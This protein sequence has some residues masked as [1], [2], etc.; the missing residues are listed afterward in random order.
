MD[1]K[2]NDYNQRVQ[3][4]NNLMLNAMG[5]YKTA[6]QNEDGSITHYT[7]DKPTLEESSYISCETSNGFAYTNDGW[8]NGAPH[9]K[10][11][12]TKDG[13]MICNVLSAV[14][15][16]ADWIKTGRI[17]SNDGSCYF[18]LDN[19]KLVANVLST[20]GIVSEWIQSGRV[21]SSSGTYGFDLDNGQLTVQN[22]AANL[23][24]TKRIQAADASCYCDLAN[25]QISMSNVSSA[26]GGNLFIFYDD[27]QEIRFACVPQNTFLAEGGV[28]YGD[29]DSKWTV[30]SSGGGSGY[31]II[32]SDNGITFSGPNNTILQKWS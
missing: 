3:A 23:L 31:R 12:M 14:G 24:K 26:A 30:I 15:V 28:G 32:V 5:V 17:E 11:G 27:E 7:H 25:R 19:N 16:V 22:I 13:N 9:W 8:N 20:V 21:E 10:Y 18:D 6:V 2:I 29:M 1:S 4:L